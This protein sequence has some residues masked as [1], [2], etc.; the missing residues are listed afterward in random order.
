MG[1]RFGV[2]GFPTLKWFPKGKKEPEAYTGGRDED[3][4]YQFILDKTGI[5]VYKKKEP[6]AVTVLN[7]ANFKSTIAKKNILVEFYAPWCGHC[8]ALAPTYEKLAKIFKTE[9]NCVVANLDATVAEDIAEEYGVQGYPT[10][11]FFKEDGT[12]EEYNSGRGLTDFIIFLNEKC[13]TDRQE[14]GGL[15]DKAG[16]VP[17]L[18]ELVAQFLE[19]KDES[20]IA[21]LKKE[22]K[23]VNTKYAKYYVKVLEKYVKNAAYPEKEWNRLQGIVKGGNTTPEKRDDF[24][25]RANIL[26]TFI[27]GVDR[28]EL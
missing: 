14:D 17:P 20:V 19:S 18:D 13:G 15:G 21:K 3:S 7:S 1:S 22:S 8:K 28:Q 6:V 16:R 24:Q 2:T 23:I 11:K 10:I 4:F 27:T 9:E 5:M 25:K 12:V 26:K